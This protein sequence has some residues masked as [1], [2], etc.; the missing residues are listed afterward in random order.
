MVDRDL[1]W[2]AIRDWWLRKI[3]HPL[4]LAMIGLFLVI[5]TLLFQL[6]R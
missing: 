6:S 5:Y 1:L 3:D 4:S 2:I